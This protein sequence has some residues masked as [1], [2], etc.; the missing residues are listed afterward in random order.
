[1]LGF[2]FATSEARETWERLGR[3]AMFETAAVPPGIAPGGT[4]RYRIGYLSLTRSELFEF[5]TD[6]QH[7]SRASVPRHRRFRSRATRRLR[8]CSLGRGYALVP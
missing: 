4:G 2:A 1:M 5:P 8:R 3:P 6:P 7:Q